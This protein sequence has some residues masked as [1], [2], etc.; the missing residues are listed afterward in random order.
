MSFK[1]TF[2]MVSP[3]DARPVKA[4]VEADNGQQA[5]E[6]AEAQYSGYRAIQILCESVD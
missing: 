2:R 4:V 6:I 1:F 3:T 5:K